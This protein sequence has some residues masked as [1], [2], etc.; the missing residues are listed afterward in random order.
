MKGVNIFK[1]VDIAQAHDGSLGILHSYIDA[2]APIGLDAIKFQ[3]HIAE[4]ESGPYEKFRVKF[5]YE[6]ATRYDYWKR[7]EFAEHQWLEIK[8]HCGDVG[9][10]FMATPFSV[11]AVELLERVGVKRY[12]VGSGDVQNFLL[13]ENIARTSK[14]IILSTGMSSLDEIDEAIKFLKPFGNEVSVL[15]CTT[16]YPSYPEEIGLNVITELKQRFNL[17]TGL[18]DHSGMI[19]PS[20]AAVAMGASIIEVHVVFDKAMF[21]L[22]SSS[23][24]TI[25]ELKLLVEGIGFIEKMLNN[26]VDK[27]KNPKIFSEEREIFGRSLSYRRDLQAGERISFETLESKKPAGYGLPPKRFREI[28]GKRIKRDVKKGDFVKEEDLR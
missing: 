15:Q 14:P 5:S 7:M 24:L 3:V 2:V 9:L 11:K 23:S 1:V 25:D 8:K 21:G 6:D 27:N 10:E 18:S 12:K 17:P 4:A 13:L 19:F 28:L 16:K 26:P 22:D 20:L